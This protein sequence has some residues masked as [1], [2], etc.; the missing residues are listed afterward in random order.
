MI[1]DIENKTLIS[2]KSLPIIFDK[3]DRF[4]GDY[5]G[6]KYLALFS[7]EKYNAIFS[8]TRYLIILKSGISYTVSHNYA[9]AEFIHMM[10]RP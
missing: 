10:I 3:V 5:N 2:K 6:I 9:K 7:S 4:I 1:F 8:R